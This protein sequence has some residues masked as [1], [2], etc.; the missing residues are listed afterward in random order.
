MTLTN[1][2]KGDEIYKEFT[3]KDRITL[4]TLSGDCEIRR[5]DSDKI[6]IRVIDSTRPRDA[7]EISIKDL[8]NSL[9]LT[10]TIHGTSHG[11]SK[12]ILTVPDDMDISFRSTSGRIEI[13]NLSG[14]FMSNSASGSSMIKNCRG[15]FDFHSASGDQNIYDCEGQFDI[16]S[17]SGDVNIR[18]ITITDLSDFGS[19]SGDI[20]GRGVI[21]KAKSNF[22]SASG[23][24]NITI[25]RSPQA[26]LDVGSASGNAL[27]DYNGI[28]MVGYFE[29]SAKKHGGVIKSDVEFEKEEE[30][31][32]NHQ[33]YI[34]KTVRF[35]DITPF[36]SVG[37]STGRAELRR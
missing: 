30:F 37:S 7:F 8:G 35:K 29:I 2:G 24:A 15:E 28:E 16:H 17:A 11:E 3:G 33:K 1:T 21:V 32:R 13:S 31:T 20:N 14:E 5:S 9:R 19:A 12:W 25:D 22:G 10:E 4:K 23:D 26:D 18:G 34:K 6:T 27:L 36:I